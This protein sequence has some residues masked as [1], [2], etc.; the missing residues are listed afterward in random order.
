MN[1]QPKVLAQWST[2]SSRNVFF[3]RLQ[4]DFDVLAK[5]IRFLVVARA[6]VMNEEIRSMFNTGVIVE[7]GKR[8]ATVMGLHLHCGHSLLDV[9]R[10]R[11][12]FDERGIYLELG[13]RFGEVL[14]EAMDGSATA[15]TIA[16]WVQDGLLPMEIEIWAVCW[17]C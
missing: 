17:E 4:A 5:E 12:P 13:P 6:E 16:V 8:A 7:P 15:G 9:R 10:Y 11:D 14:R 1:D 2:R 3:A